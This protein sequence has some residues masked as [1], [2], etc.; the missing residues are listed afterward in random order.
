MPVSA[1]AYPCLPLCQRWRNGRDRYKPTGATINPDRYQV[2]L[3]A[4]QDGR[5]FIEAHHYSRSMPATRLTVGLVHKL[6]RL[7]HETLAGVA[8]F[9]V[10]MSQSVIPKYTGLAPDQG[11][12]LGR[13]VLLDEVPANGE[14]WFLARCLALLAQAKPQIKAVVSFSDPM[15]R[16][17]NTGQVMFPGHIGLIYQASNARYCGRTDRNKLLLAP[18]GTV[19]SR[20]TLAKLTAGD[21]GAGGAYRQLLAKGAPLK[22]GYETWAAYIRRMRQEV[23][24]EVAHPGNHAYTFAGGQKPARKALRGSWGPGMPFPTLPSYPR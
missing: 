16:T 19:I 8:C 6:S 23:F 4:W 15:P 24:R 13:F 12:E 3:I 21:R 9:S 2:Q 18:D 11:V 14:S 17:T 5:A 20:R 22:P 10:P 1:P 7:H